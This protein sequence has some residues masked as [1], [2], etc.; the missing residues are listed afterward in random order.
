MSSMSKF[1]MFIK[2]YYKL[3]TSFAYISEL[4]IQQTLYYPM[5]PWETICEWQRSDADVGHM[6][7]PTLWM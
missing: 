1:V 5:N 2:H 4:H 3:P 7:K 6:T